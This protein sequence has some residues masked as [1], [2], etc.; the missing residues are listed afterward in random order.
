MPLP[1]IAT[2]ARPGGALAP[3]KRTSLAQAIATKLQEL[4][5]REQ[6]QAGDKLPTERDLALQL[7]VSRPAVREGIR[8]LEGLGIVQ[9]CHG[10]G[11]FVL[12]RQSVPLVDLSQLDSVQRLML[13]RQATEARRAVDVEVAR[14]AAR[15][16]RP[17]DLERIAGHLRAAQ[18]EPARSR[19]QF[20]L[21]L[22][23]EQLLAEAT[24]N[25]YLVAVQRV[26][27][28]IFSSAWE[29][30]GVIPRAAEQRHDQH[31]E[32]FDAI[33]KGDAELA[34][35]RMM[36]HFTLSIMPSGQADDASGPEPGSNKYGRRPH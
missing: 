34:A 30:S 28:Q 29:S 12:E 19:R 21:D 17:E 1:P 18:D 33:R 23:F 3:L 16:A 32:I 36:S 22:S 26:A 11:V 7:Q 15:D 31:D 25:E 10:K 20:S 27:H 13:L 9:V 14:L 2:S 5:G 35:Q 24:H 6:L 8:L 4:I